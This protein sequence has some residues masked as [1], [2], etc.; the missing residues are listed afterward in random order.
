MAY[1]ITRSQTSLVLS[2]DPQT[3]RTLKR[4]LAQFLNKLEGDFLNRACYVAPIQEAREAQLVIGGGNIVHALM[5]LTA[6][7]FSEHYD[8]IM[9]EGH[10]LHST[11]YLENIQRNDGTCAWATEYVICSKILSKYPNL[12]TLNDIAN[13]DMRLLLEISAAVESYEVPH[14]AG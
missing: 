14:M 10:R 9:G 12:E 6:T 3:L 2:N 11:D 8:T 4:L 1:A 13:D 5:I 7:L